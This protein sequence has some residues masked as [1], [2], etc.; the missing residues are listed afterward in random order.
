M[1]AGEEASE[2]P[3]PEQI[4]DAIRPV[5]DPELRLGVVDLGLIYR[6]ENNDGVVDVDMTLTTPF[7]PLGPTMMADVER[8]ALRVPGVKQVHVN[9]VWT[10]Q[11]DPK[12]MATE[13]VKDALN[14]W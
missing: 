13:D 4:M 3:T 7:C 12:T 8:A 1:T 6:V 9:L 11:W 14:I 10:P 5:Q 2:Q